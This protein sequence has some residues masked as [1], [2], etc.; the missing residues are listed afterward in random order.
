MSS[1]IRIGVIG[2]SGVYNIEQLQD[3]EEVVVETPF[4][5]PSDAYIVLRLG[6][7]SAQPLDRVMAEYDFCR[8]KGWDAVAKRLGIGTGCGEYRKLKAGEDLYG[9]NHGKGKAKDNGQRTE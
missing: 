2:G 6:E 1:P 9:A 7:I 4:G 8:K 5:A 3:V